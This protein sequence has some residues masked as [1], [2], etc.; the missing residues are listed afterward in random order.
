VPAVHQL[1][2]QKTGQ[3]L[4]FHVRPP[5]KPVELGKLQEAG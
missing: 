2:A 5:V 3:I 1:L 4:P